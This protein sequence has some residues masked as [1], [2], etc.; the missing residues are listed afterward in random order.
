MALIIIGT[1]R[2]VPAALA[3]AG[4]QDLSPSYAT[5]ELAV[6]N[7][8]A[9]I[10]LRTDWD[11]AYASLA[12]KAEFTEPEFQHDLTGYYPEPAHLCHARK[13][14]RAAAACHRRRRGGAAQ[15]ALVHGGWHLSELRATCM[16][17]E[18]AIVG[19]PNGP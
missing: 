7:L 13:L 3:Y 9:E 17:C 16:W 14:R 19:R 11:K 1:V 5:P 4:G 12:N 18:M 15:A 2:P 6:R 8:G 10:A